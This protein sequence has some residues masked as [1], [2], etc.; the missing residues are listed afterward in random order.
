MS[1]LSPVFCVGY[2]ECIIHC[3]CV[4]HHECIIPCILCSPLSV[5]FPLYFVQAIMNTLLSVSALSTV[6]CSSHHDYI[7]LPTLC[8]HFSLLSTVFCAAIISLL[9]TV[10]CAVII[11]AFLSI[12]SDRPDIIVLVGWALTTNRLLCT[13]CRPS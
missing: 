1:A 8:S 3:L 5:Y 13:L 7:T 9:S 6:L 10:F 4:G 12:L 11:S 2:H